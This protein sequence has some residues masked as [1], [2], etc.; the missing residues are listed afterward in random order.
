MASELFNIDR[1]RLNA[2]SV[3]PEFGC[4]LPSSENEALTVSF[5]YWRSRNQP[6]YVSD[7]R[8]SGE[9]LGRKP[10]IDEE[11]EFAVSRID[12]CNMAIFTQPVLRTRFRGF[13]K[14][15]GMSEEPTITSNPPRGKSCVFW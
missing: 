15:I 11:R 14:R 12:L 8:N 4:R 5:D 13:V 6:C 2:L 1:G 3:W 9:L 7:V 10:L